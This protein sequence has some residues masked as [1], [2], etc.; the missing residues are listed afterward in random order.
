MGASHPDLFRP[1]NID[2]N[3]LDKLVDNYLLPSGVILQWHPA[4]GKDIPAPN[5]NEIIVFT[6]FFQ[7]G[8]GLPSYD[9][10]CGLL[11]HYKIELVHLNPNSILQIVIFVHLCEADLTILPNFS[12]FKHYFFLKYQHSTTKW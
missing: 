2:E 8:F 6:A 5:T 7:R 3:D 11:H 10:L 12:L 1:L 9:F 4:Q